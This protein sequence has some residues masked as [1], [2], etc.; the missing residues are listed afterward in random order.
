MFNFFR[1][2]PQKQFTV[3]ARYHDGRWFKQFAVS[4]VTAREAA[5]KFDTSEDAQSWTRVSGAAVVTL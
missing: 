3:L 5:R 2:Q 1:R 4:A